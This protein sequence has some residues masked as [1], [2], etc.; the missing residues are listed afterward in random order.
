MS[1]NIEI[2]LAPI[3]TALRQGN[4]AVMVGAGFSFNAENGNKLKTWLGLAK[5]LYSE[6]HPN[7]Q[8]QEY[9]GTSDVLRLAEEYEQVRSRSGLDDFLREHL[10]DEKIAPG[11]LHGKLLDLSWAEI[12]T[13][14]YDTLLE[15]AAEKI[16]ERAH[17]TVFSREDIP[18]SRVLGRRRIVK[19]HGSFPSQRPFV[20]TEE[21]YRCYPIKFSPFVNL[22][23]Q[24]LLENVFC[25]IGFS[26]D[27]PNFLHWI[28]WV[29]DMLDKHTLPIY[30]FLLDEPTFGQR[31]LLESRHICP[32][33]L[34]D[35]EPQIGENKYAAGYRKLFELLSDGDENKPEDWPPEFT[36]ITHHSELNARY[37]ALL[38]SVPQ[39]KN[40]RKLYPG[41]LIAPS[42]VRGRAQ[43]QLGTLDQIWF[44]W[45]PDRLEHT[46]YIGVVV[47]E[48]FCWWQKV[49][50]QPTYDS[51][52]EC[53]IRLLENTEQIAL[54]KAPFPDD[55]FLVNS[56]VKDSAVFRE[57]WLSL[58]VSVLR[59]CREQIK[60]SQFT[61]WAAV[62][63]R[64][65]GAD[66]RLGD[67]VH[68]ETILLSIYQ[69]ESAKAE[70]E[71]LS[72]QPHLSEPYMLIRKGALLAELGVLDVGEQI[73]VDALRLI[74]RNERLDP[75]SDY[76]MSREA[77][78]CFVTHNIR[79]SKSLFDEKKESPLPPELPNLNQRL[80]NLALRNH[81]PKGE[82]ERLELGLNAE[83]PVAA[84][85]YT[86]IEFDLGNQRT[87]YHFGTSSALQDK[88]ISAFAWLHLIDYA[89]YVPRIG[90]TTWSSTSLKQAAWRVKPVENIDR[91]LSLL[92]RLQT[93]DIL[94]PRES[95]T[96]PHTGGWFSRYEVASLTYESA[97]ILCKHSL[98]IADKNLSQVTSAWNDKSVGFH[99][100]LYSRL[101]LRETDDSRL[102]QY[103]ERLLQLY[104]DIR[105]RKQIF[106]WEPFGHAFMRTLE[107]LPSSQ[108]E[109]IVPRLLALPELDVTLAS[110]PLY[111][112]WPEWSFIEEHSTIQYSNANLIS[113]ARQ[114]TRIW[115]GKLNSLEDNEQNIHIAS[116]F[117]SRIY[118]CERHGLLDSETKDAIGNFIW[119][120]YTTWPVVSGLQPLAPLDWPTPKGFNS[121]KLLQEWIFTQVIP[122]ILNAIPN[123]PD[124]FLLSWR[125]FPGAEGWPDAELIQGIG[126]IRDWWST[127][128][129][130][131][132]ETLNKEKEQAFPFNVEPQIKRRFALLDQIFAKWLAGRMEDLAKSDSVLIDWVES[133]VE[134][135]KL[136][137]IPFWRFRLARNLNSGELPLDVISELW[138]AFMGSG[139]DE[140]YNAATVVSFWIGQLNDLYPKADKTAPDLLLDTMVIIVAM[141]HMPALP[142]VL[143]VLK[144]IADKCPI[145]LTESK[146]TLMSSGLGRLYEELSYGKRKVESSIPNEL[147][148]QLRFSCAELAFA[149]HS[150][151]IQSEFIRKWM[152]ACPVDPL[153]EMRSLKP[154]K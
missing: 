30:L 95:N 142:R 123:P 86:T 67:E 49:I 15:R 149:L 109:V 82:I 51:A 28:G 77:W 153:P 146:I 93:V 99:F 58:A 132:A 112:N 129:A 33:V 35:V 12:F 54:G 69:G 17:F 71:L 1:E 144:I 60:V 22:V 38:D 7:S 138:Q 141:R 150:K 130:A 152:D 75:D 56:D 134:L 84:V 14:N 65:S 31:K 59:W 21:D 104:T 76:L 140:I 79:R 13:T 24:S 120:N 70:Q 3:R 126:L 43:R 143:E 105:I 73:C 108:F 117:W 148:P 121:K 47:M 11:L 26:G 78:A 46:P 90:N 55:A 52:A 48:E 72:W 113:S 96:P 106:V 34:P 100:E 114:I 40:A 151:G 98:D 135:A 116:R 68:H 16:V 32:V 37:A 57:I 131:C 85:E 63:E 124:I 103:F 101:V 87:G 29:R 118:W 19:L 133:V 41:W 64:V 97:Q 139:E 42:I 137:G 25:L 62:I 81:D 145:W 74:R 18:R 44:P 5:A 147:I 88:T 102:L 45:V 27:D 127:E 122:R 125:D 80:N 2:H 20:F 23:R 94:K 6:L 110:H 39:L 4:A 136:E 36:V 107:A 154:T 53:A 9:F 111:R 89:G 66:P 92:I 83:A 128:W 10:P 50:L 115:L 8:I 61:Y 91:V 119:R